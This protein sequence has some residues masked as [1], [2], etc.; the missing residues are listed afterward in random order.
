MSDE[1]GAGDTARLVVAPVAALE[2]EDESLQEE[3][4]NVGELGIDDG[5]QGGVHVREGRRGHLQRDTCGAKF[6]LAGKS[7]NTNSVMLISDNCPFR[8]CLPITFICFHPFSSV[9]GYRTGI[10]AG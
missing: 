6:E 8:K 2:V 10:N 4:A 3:L 7:R 5:S 1:P 9:S